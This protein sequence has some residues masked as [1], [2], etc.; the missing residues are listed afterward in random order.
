MAENYEYHCVAGPTV[1]SVK[2]QE[3]LSKAVLAFEGIINKEAA[4]GW[5]YVGID[6]FQTSEPQGC[7]G[8]GTPKMTVLKM[9]VFKRHRA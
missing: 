8:M 1:I 3:D 6:E 7:L 4:D 2:K 9:L 5:E